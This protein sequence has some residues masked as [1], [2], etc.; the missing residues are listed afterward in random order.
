MSDERDWSQHDHRRARRPAG[1]QRLLRSRE[2]VLGGVAAGIA[3]LIGTR[4]SVVRLLWLASLPLSGGITG[5]AYLLLWLMLPAQEG[6]G[7]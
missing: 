7:A 3:D 2:A 4:A 6:T 1:D 5:L